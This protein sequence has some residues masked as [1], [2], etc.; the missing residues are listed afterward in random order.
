MSVN[1]YHIREEPLNRRGIAKQAQ[2]CARSV[3]RNGCHQSWP[4][5]AAISQQ[6]E[7]EICPLARAPDRPPCTSEDREVEKNDRVGGAKPDF[8]GIVGSQVA[9]HDPPG[10]LDKPLLH[11]FP[12]ITWGCDQPWLPENLVQF[13][14]RQARNC[15]QARGQGRFA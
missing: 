9:I 2:V 14:H 8:D 13:Y 4:A 7:P 12:L 5:L 1:V 6:P 15:A 10:L 3:I 11:H